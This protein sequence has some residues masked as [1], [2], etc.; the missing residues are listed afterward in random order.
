MAYFESNLA[1][2]YL[3]ARGESSVLIVSE[4]SISEYR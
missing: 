3:L 1:G 4:I 2:I